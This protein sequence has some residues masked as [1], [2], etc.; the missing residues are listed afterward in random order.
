MRKHI[1]AIILCFTVGGLFC[2]LLFAAEYTV[3][4]R[5]HQGID[6]AIKKWQPTIDVLNR[7]IPQHTFILLPIISIVEIEQRAG[8]GEVQFILTNPSSFVDIEKLYGA[9]ALLTLN[10][11][12]AN[13]AQSRF[14]SVIF[15]HVRNTDILTLKDLQDK[16]LMAVSELAFGGW[17]VAWLEMLEQGFNPYQGLKTLMFTQGETQPE[18]V[19][20][21]RDGIA[22]AGVV[23][24]D[25][26]ER[27]ESAG[28]IDMRYFRILNNKDVKGFPFFLSTELYPEWAFAVLKSVPSELSQQIKN[29]LLSITVESTAAQKGRY[30]GWISP[31]DY[32]PVKELM[33]QLQVGSYAD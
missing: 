2:N 20:A 23:R 6:G 8:R 7:E 32:L 18:V 16:T 13:T 1:V 26:L 24:T 5:A 14:G 29:V 28:E 33:R 30:V 19:R 31:L 25:R 3:A 17:R 9:H 11:K 27:M 10:N 21:V 22:H 15:T 12:R 4:V